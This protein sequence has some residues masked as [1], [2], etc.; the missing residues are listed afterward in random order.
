[1]KGILTF[2]IVARDNSTGEVG[3]AV[4]SG[5][6][7]AGSFVSWA[8]AS[9]GGIAIQSAINLDHGEIGIELLKKGYTAQQVMDSLLALD[10][11][12]EERQIGI[13]DLRGNSAVHTGKHCPVW[14]GHV[15]GKNFTCQGNFLQ[16]DKAV[17]LMAETFLNTEGHLSIRLLSALEAGGRMA[18]D[19]SARQSAALLVVKDRGS[20]VGCNGKNIDLRVDYDIEPVK[21]LFELLDF[22]ETHTRKN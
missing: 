15:K 19:K 4:Q 11:D 20:Y 16:E 21:K 13:V 17:E 3:V 12:R 2:S 18:G 22:Y 9:A 7:A 10:T 6:P 5:F 1:M 8:K 14:S